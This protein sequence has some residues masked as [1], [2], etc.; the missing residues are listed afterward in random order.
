MKITHENLPRRL[1]H[2]IALLYKLKLVKTEF[3]WSWNYDEEDVLRLKANR[4]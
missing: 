4:K 2:F 1:E 3:F